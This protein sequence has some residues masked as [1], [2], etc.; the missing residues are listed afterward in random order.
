MPFELRDAPVSHAAQFL[1]A[2]ANARQ[3]KDQLNALDQI[4]KNTGEFTDALIE[5]CVFMQVMAH[6]FTTPPTERSPQ[7]MFGASNA[8]SHARN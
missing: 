4:L 7:A 3:L 1:A 8:E 6:T 2:F 5:T